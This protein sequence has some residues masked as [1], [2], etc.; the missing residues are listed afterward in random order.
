MPDCLRAAEQG[1]DI[2]VRNPNSVRPYQHVLEPLAA[3]MMIA[4]EQYNNKEVCGNYN[5]GPENFDCVT[6]GVLASMFCELWRNGLSWN[7]TQT[8]GPHEANFLK[9]DCSKI[10]KVFGWN[11]TWDLKKALEKT[12]EWH[13]TYLSGTGIE[14][15]TSRQIDEFMKG[16]N[17]W[18]SI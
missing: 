3:Y 17:K 10:K 14:Q 2:F 8:E 1:K 12:I 16:N 4:Q 6:T 5:I 13:Q 15:I 18:Q 9:L 7:T 11:S